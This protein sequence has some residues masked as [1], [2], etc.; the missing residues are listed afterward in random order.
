[1]EPTGVPIDPVNAARGAEDDAMHF[2]DE[3][4]QPAT[5]RVSDIFAGS[6]ATLEGALTTLVDRMEA[7]VAE[8]G[9]V[10][11]TSAGELREVRVRAEQLF[12]TLPD[13]NI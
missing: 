10:S 3:G 8:Q 12:R 5:S 13:G 9:M 4:K 2:D 1:L 6:I 7:E 11:A